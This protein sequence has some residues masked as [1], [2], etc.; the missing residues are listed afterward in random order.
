MIDYY[1]P[2]TGLKTLSDIEP[3]PE[4][5]PVVEPGSDAGT[6]SGRRVNAR[7]GASPKKEEAHPRP[8]S[9]PKPL[10]P[11]NPGDT[12]KRGEKPLPG[13]MKA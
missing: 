7:E 2:E 3:D 11:G 10:T 6:E 9:E 12:Q 5:S 1:Q 13:P 8:A 4:T